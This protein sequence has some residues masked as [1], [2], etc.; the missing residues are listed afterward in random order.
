[1]IDLLSQFILRQKRCFHDAPVTASIALGGM[2]AVLLSL[3][4]QEPINN[5]PA[6][7]AEQDEIRRSQQGDSDAFRKLVERH[8]SHVGKLLWRFTRDTDCHEE[9]VQ[10]TFVQAYFSLNTYKAQAPFEHWLTRIATRVGYR[11]WKQKS[12]HQH[13]P[14]LENEWDDLAGSEVPN[15]TPGE[16]AEL[17]HHLLAQLPPRDRLVLT[18]RFLE[19]CDVVETAKRTGWT[20]TMVKVQTHRAKE[21]LKTLAEKADIEIDV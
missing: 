17:I 19:Q 1:M 11:F 16:A 13:Q 15:T 14:L 8:Q 2:G 21:K 6:G 4:N 10:E 9:L 12:K 5:G 3:T 18:L 7:F 20:A